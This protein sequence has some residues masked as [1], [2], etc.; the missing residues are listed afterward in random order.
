M[1]DPKSVTMKLALFFVTITIYVALSSAMPYSM[2]E[3]EEAKENCEHILCACAIEV[4]IDS[5][6]IV[7]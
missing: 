1:R 5:D 7:L 4:A 2:E 6:I 3:K